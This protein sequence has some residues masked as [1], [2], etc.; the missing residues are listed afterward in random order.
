MSHGY[1]TERFLWARYDFGHLPFIADWPSSRLSCSQSKGEAEVSCTQALGFRVTA[2]RVFEGGY[3]RRTAPALWYLRPPGASS[4]VYRGLQLCRSPVTVLGRGLNSAPGR[5][6]LARRL[7]AEIRQASTLDCPR[8][9]RGRVCR[10]FAPSPSSVRLCHSTV[11]ASHRNF[12]T[13]AWRI[14][15]TKA[16]RD[17]TMALRVPSE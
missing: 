11:A 12:W 7:A 9:Q 14:G 16:C 15:E 1:C 5:F 17:R 3:Q 8:E 4:L 10:T 6:R 2:V 13:L